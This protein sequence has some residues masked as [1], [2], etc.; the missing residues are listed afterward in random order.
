[1]STTSPAHRAE[2]TTTPGEPLAPLAAVSAAV[3][4]ILALLAAFGLPLTP[5]QTA[6]VLGVVG[7]VGPLVVWL[8]G[9]RRVVPTDNVVAMVAKSGALVAGD[10]A[11]AET[12][13]PVTVTTEP[14][15]WAA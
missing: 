14:E 7:T 3:A 12:G 2:D 9:R 5:D 10:G 1:M 8:L 13:T 11:A 6:A 4:A 15:R